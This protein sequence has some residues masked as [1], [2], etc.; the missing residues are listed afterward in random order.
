MLNAVVAI[1]AGAVCFYFTTKIVE[2]HG[3]HSDAKAWP[4]AD[5]TITHVLKSI[6]GRRRGGSRLVLRYEFEIDGDTYW[7]TGLT[8][9]GNEVG[10]W[11]GYDP[12]SDLYEAFKEGTPST[13]TT[14][15]TEDLSRCCTS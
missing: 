4:R 8:V 1:I 3:K 9:A 11:A 7:G 2:L 14:T 13:S 12:Y 6:G 10:L 5:G 15:R